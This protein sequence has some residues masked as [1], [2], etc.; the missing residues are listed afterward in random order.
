MSEELKITGWY[1]RNCQWLLLLCLLVFSAAPE[2]LS[3]QSLQDGYVDTA[4]LNNPGL[5]EQYSA[6]EAGVQ[7]VAQVSGL[8]NPELGVGVF[9]KPV[10]TR[11]GPQLGRVSLS[12]K[13]PWFGTLAARG[14]AAAL[15]AEATYYQFV[16]AREK[17]RSEVSAAFYQLWALERQAKLEQENVEVLK[18]F[19]ELATSEVSSGEGKLSDVYRV[20]LRIAEAQRRLESLQK[21]QEVLTSN[22]NR[23][24]NRNPR[25]RVK[26]PDTLE[27]L[28]PSVSLQDSAL[29]P[30]V[31]V[32]SVLR[33]SAEFDARAASKSAGP[34]FGVGIDYVAVGKR[35]ATIENNGRDAIMPMISVSLPVWQSQ[36][37]AAKKE[38]E[39][40][41]QQYDLQLEEYSN[42]L[43][44]KAELAR[45][46]L[47]EAKS[48][49]HLY[50]EE[51]R[52]AQ[53]ALELTL[54]DYS[55]AR[56][57]FEEVLRLQQKIINYRK[58]KLQAVEALY[59][60]RVKLN[61]ANY[62]LTEEDQQPKIN[63]DNE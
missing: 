58:Q 56:E 30:G 18:S 52:L 4:L 11:V 7:Q 51:V 34:S 57:D 17:L 46:D 26:L 2:S 1:K 42:R 23:L 5:R 40:R 19:E 10:E 48:N 55:N 22:F 33:E 6:F 15:R 60:A 27:T 21:R 50:Q 61:Y 35:D 47:S 63:S 37:R 16:N 13:F 38:A 41:Q 44:D 20:Q 14:D 12:Q 53:K 62:Q 59:T 45:F 28:E 25:K 36:Y 43:A 29:H 8:P 49:I 24:L 39:I 31:K 3:G 54:T 9:L 32:A